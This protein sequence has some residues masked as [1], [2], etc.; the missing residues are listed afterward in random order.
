MSRSTRMQRRPRRPLSLRSLRL[1]TKVVLVLGLSALI[2][3]VTMGG[4]AVATLLYAHLPGNLPEQK[5]ALVAI[6]SYVYDSGGNNIGVFRQFELTVPIQPSDIPQVLKDAVVAAEDRRFWEH[7]GVDAR[8]VLRAA[9]TDYNEG[10]T[11]QGG[12]TITQQY[13][14][15]NYL[16]GDR[17]LSRKLREAILATQLE[18]RMS[19]ADILFNYLNTV[20]FGSGAYGVGAA[21]QSY[22]GKPVSQLTLSESAMLAG[23]IPAPTE[24]SPRVN[25]QEAERRRELVLDEMLKQKLISQAD[26]DQAKALGLWLVIDGPPPAPATLVQPQPTKGASQYPYFVDWVEQVMLAKYG[27]E[28][29]YRGGL[30]IETTIDPRLQFYADQAVAGRLAGT[31]APLDMSLVTVEPSTGLVR[32]MVAGRDSNA[33]QVNLALGGTYGFQPGSSFKTFVLTEA[34]EQGIAPETIYNAP[35][36]FRIP[37]CDGDDCF[38]GNYADGQ[39]YGRMTLR[40]ATAS[41]INTVFAELISDVGVQKTAEMAHRL[42]VT[43][44]DPNGNYGVSLALGAAEVSPLDMASAYATLANQ[45]VRIDPTPILRVIDHDGHILEDNNHRQGTR[46]VS[47]NVAANVTNVLQDVIKSGTGTAAAIDRP[48]A[49]K[50]GTAEEYRA[51]WFVGYTPQLS[52]AVWTGYTDAQRSL[53]GTTGGSTPARTWSDFMRPAMKDLPVQD[54]PPPAKLVAEPAPQASGGAGPAPPVTTGPPDTTVKAPSQAAPLETPHD[55]GG[56]CQLYSGPLN[57]PITLQNTPAAVSSASPP[58]T[59]ASSG[60]AAP[61]DTTPRR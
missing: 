35:A 16:T 34:F 42:G 48:A 19:K 33:S 24:W 7:K 3:P 54:F 25:S 43:N 37:N 22:F 23:L 13:V 39:G 18:R 9:W 46:A 32:A 8:G 57:L 4:I 14:K 6:P 28:K 36:Q 51:A 58:T 52:T 1:G 60:G 20:Y 17:T 45:G 12:S 49:G 41:S 10:D 53:P 2:V 11:V 15:N 59:S 56:S 29:V 47:A 5:P 30:R 31:S 26:H 21:A 40:K 27:P 61:A 50:T 44:V 55:C 38:L